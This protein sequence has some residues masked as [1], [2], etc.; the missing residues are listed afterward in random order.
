[1]AELYRYR[2]A[3]AH[4][5]LAGQA[6]DED[7]VAVKMCESEG[8]TQLNLRGPVE[9]AKFARAAK[10]AL[11]CDLP[12]TPNTVNE[13]DGVRTLWLEPDEWLLVAAPMSAGLGLLLVP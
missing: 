7:G 9:D 8:S 5:G 1:M 6:S 13:A 4:L 2:S 3:L 11:G 10:R 12:T